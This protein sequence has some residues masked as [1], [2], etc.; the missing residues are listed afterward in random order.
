MKIVQ[1]KTLARLINEKFGPEYCATCTPSRS[2]TDRK[3]AGTRLIHKGKGRRGYRL[4]VSSPPDGEGPVVID[5]DSSQCYR[6]NAEAMDK[7]A[8]LF[9]EIWL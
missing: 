2:S 5:H 8:T 4:R 3:L 6:T 7:V 1:L 9:G